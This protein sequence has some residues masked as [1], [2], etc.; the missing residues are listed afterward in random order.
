MSGG[1]V[2]TLRLSLEERALA[3]S[4]QGIGTRIEIADDPVVP[5]CTGGIT[6][7]TSGRITA[8][9]I[10][11]TGRAIQLVLQLNGDGTGNITGSVAGRPLG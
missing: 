5:A 3:Q 9:C 6:Q 7:A 11:A 1:T 2:G 8:T 10:D 4:T